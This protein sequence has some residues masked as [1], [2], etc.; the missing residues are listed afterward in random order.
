V[1][2]NEYLH[3][4]TRNTRRLASPVIQWENRALCFPSLLLLECQPRTTEVLITNKIKSCIQ[5]TFF[6][7]LVAADALLKSCTCPVGASSPCVG[8]ADLSTGRMHVLNVFKCGNLEG[9]VDVATLMTAVT[10][11][12]TFLNPLVMSPRPITVRK[13]IE[14]I[15]IVILSLLPP[16][17]PASCSHCCHAMPFL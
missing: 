4:R 2:I 7:L 10:H 6:H 17:L 13:I 16:E 12:D 14:P 15:T 8:S 3:N 9:L 5:G 11:L 1:P